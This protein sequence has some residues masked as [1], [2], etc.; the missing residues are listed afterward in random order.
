MTHSPGRRLRLAV[1]LRHLPRDAGPGA[2]IEHASTELID[3]LRPLADRRGIELVCFTEPKRAWYFSHT[4]KR[5]G[6]R[7]VLVPS[8]SVAPFLKIPT[9]PWVHDLAIFDHPEWFPQYPPRRWL[10]TRYF[11]RGVRRARHVFCVSE[12]TKQSLIRIA[13]IPADRITVTYQAIR[14]PRMTSS[15]RGVDGRYALI[16]GTVE[17]RKNIPFIVDLWPRVIEGM[18]TPPCLVIAGRAGWGNVSEAIAHK[19]DKLTCLKRLSEVS[20]RERDALIEHAS[21]LLVPSLH[22]GFGRTALEGLSAGAPVIAS[23]RG[24][25]PEILGKA[26]VLLEPNDKAGWVEAMRNVFQSKPD[27]A[28]GLERAKLFSWPKTAA[29]M[30][31]KIIE[32]W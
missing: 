1:D 23:N 19:A 32:T 10:T 24:A 5:S 29:I 17:P 11:L 20:D 2:G 27:V 14:E 6:A 28:L 25:L 8:G 26:G 7:A 3:A 12:D 13:R 30:L 9:Y 4:I 31:A 16:M 21:V 15:P 18:V 22:E